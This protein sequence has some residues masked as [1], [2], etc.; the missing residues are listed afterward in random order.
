MSREERDYRSYLLRLWRT[1]RKG[2][3]VWRGSI[4]SPHTGQRKAFTNLAGLLAFLEKE[5]GTVAENRPAPDR[6]GEGGDTGNRLVP[7]G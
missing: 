4:E 6:D 3:P 5:I 2:E 1:R 7:G